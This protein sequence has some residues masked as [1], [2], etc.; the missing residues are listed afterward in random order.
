MTHD[1]ARSLF[2][3]RLDGVAERAIAE[4]RVGDDGVVDIT[5]TYTPPAARGRGL[6]ASLV[7]A[8]V[9]WARTTGAPGVR[10]SCSYVRDTWLPPALAAATPATPLRYDADANLVLFTTI[11]S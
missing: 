11:D 2:Y 10:P 9:A 7:D 5:H 8:V 6:A 3:V 1:A 4:Y